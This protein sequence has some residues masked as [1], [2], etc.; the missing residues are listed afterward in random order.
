MCVCACNRWLLNQV[1]ERNEVTAEEKARL[2][3]LQQEQATASRTQVNQKRK[4]RISVL[5][6]EFERLKVMILCVHQNKDIYTGVLPTFQVFVKK[7]QHEKP[8][9]H[10]LHVEMVALVRELL[11]KFMK[12]EAI[13]LSVKEILKVDV[14]SRDL[15]LSNKRLCVGRFCYSAMNKARVER[16]IWVGNLYKSLREGYIKSAEFLL[17][18]LPLDNKTIT[19]LSAL[20]PCLIQCDSVCGAFMALGE[21]L[22]HVV[23]SEEVSQLEEEV[24]AYQID[25]DLLPQ[26]KTYVEEDSRVNI[27]WWSRVASLKNAER[28]VRYPTLIKLVK[29]LLSIFTGPLVEGSFNL[30]DDILET[31]RCSLNVE[32]YESLAVVKSTMKARDWTA[33]TI[34]IDQPL[35]RS[36]LSSYQNYQLHL[37]KR[38]IE[39]RQ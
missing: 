10:L 19:S 27:D 18:N 30:M 11:S 26:A 38:M 31:D 23:P 8:M 39:N 13:P 1:L 12:P 2:D 34:T 20:T 32:T 33:S 22:P 7:L 24:W 15:Q 5:F 6:T 28:G 3:V 37:K 25:S 17:K 35:R 14:Q 16:K 21:A 36:C 4:A 9:V 29:A